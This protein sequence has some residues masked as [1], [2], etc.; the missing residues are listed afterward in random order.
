[1]TRWLD[2]VTAIFAVAAGGYCFVAAWFRWPLSNIVWIGAANGF[3]A[4]ADK[5]MRDLK[6]GSPEGQ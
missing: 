6:R 5:C 4:L 3:M 2:V 1:M